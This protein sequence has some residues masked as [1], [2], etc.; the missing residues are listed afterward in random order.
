MKKKEILPQDME[1]VDAEKAKKQTRKRK[2]DVLS[3]NLFPSD[4]D[5]FLKKQ[6]EM[7]LSE[8]EKE[9]KSSENSLNVETEQE[10]KT[11]SINIRSLSFWIGAVA[12]GLGALEAILIWFN[13]K[14]EV[15]LLVEGISTVLFTLVCL[16][17]LKTNN[18][19]LVKGDIKS[20]I[21]EKMKDEKK[22]K[23]SKDE[24]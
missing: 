8:D 17:V 3:V 18:K 11:K 21:E 24:E 13:V 1:A 10:E 6:N 23:E 14:V 12:V 16:G 22:D 2:V 20:D 19:K 5:D 15:N 4:D 7:F 9:N